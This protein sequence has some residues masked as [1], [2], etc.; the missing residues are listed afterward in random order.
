M[1]MT[2]FLVGVSVAILGCSGDPEPS[3]G[4]PGQPNPGQWGQASPQAGPPPRL[5]TKAEECADLISVVN[6]GVAHVDQA[7][8]QAAKA[9]KPELLAMAAALDAV[10]NET[11]RMGFLDRDLLRIGG[12]YVGVLRLQAKTTRELD[13]AVGRKDE[14]AVKQ[15]QA[16]LSAVEQQEKTILDELNRTCGAPVGKAG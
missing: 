15:K 10:A 6:A 16:D 3:P 1:G 7:T 14:A 11:E 2:R 5:P 4:W 9:G 8:E 13:A 12:F